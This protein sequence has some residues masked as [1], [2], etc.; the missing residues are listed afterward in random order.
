[1]ILIFIKHP[2]NSVLFFVLFEQLQRNNN[3]LLFRIPFN[4]ST[5]YPST[6]GP[7]IKLKFTIHVDR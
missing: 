3:I 4:T 2:E 7:L 1:V 5:K 6:C